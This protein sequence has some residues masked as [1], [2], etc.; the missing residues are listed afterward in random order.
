MTPIKARRILA[1]VA[2]LVLLGAFVRAFVAPLSWPLW[3]AVVAY[4]WLVA[5][6]DRHGWLWYDHAA[7]RRHEAEDRA[8][9]ADAFA[10]RFRP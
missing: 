3:F 1:I 2:S 7:A 5:M 6:A 10:P 4:V 8:R 9:E